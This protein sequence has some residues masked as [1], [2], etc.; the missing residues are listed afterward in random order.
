MRASTV[1]FH[2]TV[3]CASLASVYSILAVG[4][5]LDVALAS[6]PEPLAALGDS[7]G[8]GAGAA[9]AAG[10]AGRLTATLAI[11]EAIGPARLALT[12]TA[13]PGVSRVA[14]RVQAVRDAEAWVQQRWEQFREKDDRD[15]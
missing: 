15:R 12:V 10:A 11:V 9:S 7:I 14:R 4:V 6:L 5:D 8:S 3:W 2:F 1:L 13:T